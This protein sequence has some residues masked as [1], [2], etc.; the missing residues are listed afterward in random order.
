MNKPEKVK[1]QAHP[2]ETGRHHTRQ[3]RDEKRVPGVVYGP[4]L[5]EN[6]HFAINELDLEKILSSRDLQLVTLVFG[7]KTKVDTILKAVEFHPV[8]DRPLHVDFYA[9]SK[10]HAVT[11]TVPLLFT[12]TAVG[13][14]EG[15]RLYRST[16]ELRVTCLPDAIPANISVDISKLTIGSTLHIRDIEME[17]V[18]PVDDSGRTLATVRPPRTGVQ[19]TVTEEGGEPEAEEAGAE[20]EAEAEEAG[21]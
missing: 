5:D 6:R 3:L 9:L 18:T 16:R 1:L 12:G 20:E 19:A 7:D 8:T 10:D 2:R 4:A 11:V 14:I 13:V 15:G 21:E 17:G